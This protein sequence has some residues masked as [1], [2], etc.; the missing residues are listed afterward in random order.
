MGESPNTPVSRR[1]LRAQI[2]VA[3]LA[4][5]GIILFIVLYV[6]FEGQTQLTRLLISLCIP[7]VVIALFVGTYL[8][9]TAGRP[10]SG[11]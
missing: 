6:A 8:L 4:V 5:L 7:P 1:L 10:K 3:G 11:S 9:V 2:A